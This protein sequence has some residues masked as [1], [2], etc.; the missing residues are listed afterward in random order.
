ME[1]KKYYAGIGSRQTPKDI[2]GVMKRLAA[3]LSEDGWT[4]R[5]GGAE[6]ADKAFQAGAD[7]QQVIV[8]RPQHAQAN[9][10]QHA[11]LFHPAWDKCSDYAKKLHGRNS[12]IILGV[13]LDEPVKFVVC[14]TP[15]AQLKGGTAQGMRIAQRNDIPIFNLANPQHLARIKAYL[16]GEKLR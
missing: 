6:G 11:A 8:F 3:K 9:H 7:P 2:L 12:M 1:G 4:L 5:S 16:R 14:W 10:L 15:G 13:G